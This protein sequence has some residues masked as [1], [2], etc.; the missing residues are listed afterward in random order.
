MHGS[1]IKDDG[2]TG[3][4]SPKTSNQLKDA[5][6]AGAPSDHQSGC[7]AGCACERRDSQDVVRDV[8]AEELEREA[9]GLG[10]DIDSLYAAAYGGAP[11][12]EEPI[13]SRRQ[14]NQNPR[15]KKQAEFME[16]LGAE[17]ALAAL[18]ISASVSRERPAET[19]EK[20]AVPQQPD[21]L[22]AGECPDA[23]EVIDTVKP[24]VS[25]FDPLL[26]RP[27]WIV[28]PDEDLNRLAEHLFRE[29]AIGWLIADLNSEKIKDT[30]IDGKRVVELRARQRITLPV[31]QDIVIFHKTKKSNAKPTNLIT[32]VSKN[33]VDKEIMNAAL[34]KAL[35]VAKQDSGL[36]PATTT[37]AGFGL[38]AD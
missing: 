35:G 26:I 7:E 14:R 23:K 4:E 15:G 13:T 21:Q 33:A 28:R 6:G 10:D 2:S 11:P 34:S 31:W 9:K 20:S 24:V 16:M 1:E 25:S 37:V 17:I 3:G 27:T 18:I 30:L 22:K 8:A 29:P 36:M 32:M 19:K 38:I 5:L 12:P